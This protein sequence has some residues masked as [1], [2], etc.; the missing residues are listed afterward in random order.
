[1]A[2]GNSVASGIMAS[3]TSGYSARSRWAKSLCTV[4]AVEH[5]HDD[6]GDR[7]GVAACLFDQVAPVADLGQPLAPVES[8]WVGMSTAS[9]AI[10]AAQVFNWR[11]GRS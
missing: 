1:M 3:R 11:L 6:A 7:H 2:S 8:G 10:S 5:G 9:A 4:P